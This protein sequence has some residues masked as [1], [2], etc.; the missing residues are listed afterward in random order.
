VWLWTYPGKHA[1]SSPG[2]PEISARAYAKFFSEAAPYIIGG[3]LDNDTDRFMFEVLNLYVF[4]KLAWYPNLDI[5]ALLDDWNGRLFGSAKAEM[6]AVYDLLEDRWVGGVCKGRVVE[7][8]LG[9]VTVK[10]S[11]GQL[12]AGIYSPST[13][14]ELRRLFDAAM[15]KT[16][17]GSLEARRVALL[18]DE[19]LDSL[20]K[21]SEAADPAVELRR[22]AAEKPVNIIA[23]G[24]FATKDGWKKEV[25]WGTAELDFDT[26]V[27]GNASVRI[28][29]DTVPHRKSNVQSDFVTYVPLYTNRTY[30]LSYFIKTKDV[31]PYVAAN[32][33][34][35][36]V[37]MSWK[38][39]IKL[40]HL[41]GSCGWVHQ[42]HVFTPEINAPKTR[43][44]FRVE[45]S[46]GTMWIDG[47]LLEDITE[48]TRK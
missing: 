23:N 10:P 16:A 37:W 41:R 24:D 36:V 8:A 21:Q 42:S 34:G 14:V 7:S 39:Y 12:W 19:F 47:V 28:T 9:P 13:I 25:S 27:T 22:R 26:K 4:A 29:S 30:R 5:E 33:A 35:P 43:L 45:D 11:V 40:P 32:G 38:K 17:P 6:K 2:I 44:Q 3:Y 18:R 31:V 46:L 1:G 15:A 20:A 48:K